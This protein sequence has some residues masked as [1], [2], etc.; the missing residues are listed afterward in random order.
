MKDRIGGRELLQYPVYRYWAWVYWGSARWLVW[1]MDWERVIDGGWYS[2]CWPFGSRSIHNHTS[3]WAGCLHYS[4]PSVM[5]FATASQ[6]SLVTLKILNLLKVIL[7]TAFNKEDAL[8][9][10]RDLLREVW[11]FASCWASV[12][13]ESTRS[14]P[15]KVTEPRH[16][17]R[18]HLHCVR[19]PAKLHF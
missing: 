6:F 8:V 10:S 12:S 1:C 4:H 3:C 16:R 15:P 18:E 13:C 11:N 5:I 19:H 14:P 7:V 17:G 2:V 9:G